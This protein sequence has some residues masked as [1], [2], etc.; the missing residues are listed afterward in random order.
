MPL[1]ATQRVTDS[2]RSAGD[3]SA[4]FPGERSFNSQIMFKPFLNPFPLQ[5]FFRFIK[6]PRASS[7]PARERQAG[8]D[9]CPD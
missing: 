6:F 8:R 1:P 9:E 5:I 2:S 3:I 4:A 7:S